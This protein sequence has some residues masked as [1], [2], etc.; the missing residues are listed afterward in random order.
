MKKIIDGIKAIWENLIEESRAVAAS[1]AVQRN[2][3]SDVD[4]HRA[5]LELMER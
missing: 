2:M 4:L 1:D 5:A 3:D